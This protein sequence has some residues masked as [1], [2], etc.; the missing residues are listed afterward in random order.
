MIAVLAILV[1]AGVG[2]LVW[3]VARSVGSSG[4]PSAPPSQVDPAV[5][6]NDLSVDDMVL[7]D[8]LDE[9]LDG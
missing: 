2:V 6:Q 3:W 4:R 7:M 9:D 8:M 1:L 5:D